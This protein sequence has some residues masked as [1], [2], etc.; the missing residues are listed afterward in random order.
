MTPT[1]NNISLFV[2]FDLITR[3][4]NIYTNL[5]LFIVEQCNDKTD[6]KN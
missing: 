5:R 6:I 4:F 3:L 1:A 2:T